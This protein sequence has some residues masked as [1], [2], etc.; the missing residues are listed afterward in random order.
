MQEFLLQLG[1][2]IINLLELV[3]WNV[4]NN[5]IVYAQVVIKVLLQN[6]ETF[7]FGISPMT[8]MQSTNQLKSVIFLL[9]AAVDS[10]P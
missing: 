1:H 8:K 4:G 9:T 2:Q 7:M 5:V 6:K 3:M 10:M